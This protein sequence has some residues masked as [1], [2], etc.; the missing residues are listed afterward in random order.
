MYKAGL[1]LEGGGM[2]GIF[3]A[4][5]LDLLM[6][7]NIMFSD[8]YGVSAGACHM[9]SYIS[10]QRGRAFDI[11]VDYLD[12]RWYCGIP[13][14]LF[15][16]NLFNTDIAYGLVP[17]A[18]NPFDHD[19]Y[20]RYEGNAYS[21]VTD[22]E[23]G[24]PGYLRMKSC[25]GKNMDKLRASASLP[26]VARMVEIGGR[27]YL[28]GG[29]SDAIPLERSIM[30]GND[31]NLVILTKEVGYVRTPIPE[32]E[33]ALLKLRYAAYP[34]VWK[35]MRN[36]DIRYNKQLAFVERMEKEGKAFVL[37]PEHKSNTKRID[38]DP[39]HLK[40]LYEEGYKLAAERFDDLK[41]YLDS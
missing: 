1:V 28:D 17:D 19:A 9:T 16:G 15:T 10:G 39:E 6:D 38:K 13:S 29:L 3:T 21:V 2:K 24:E 41:R 37:R 36:R 33:L 31:K 5:V 11:S 40:A 26:L 30:S 4:G 23:T 34:N 32:R 22:V 25:R 8:I 20:E 7:K 14:L 18:L 12:T 27:K 35:L